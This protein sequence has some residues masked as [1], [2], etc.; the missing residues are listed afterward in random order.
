MF[1]VCVARRSDGEVNFRIVFPSDGRC[2]FW[3]DCSRIM[4]SFTPFT[5]IPMDRDCS[6]IGRSPAPYVQDV[7]SVPSSQGCLVATSL[8]ICVR[9]DQSSMSLAPAGS[10]L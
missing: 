1:G 8:D 7:T 10:L 2:A 4:P 9:I 6:L 3:Q 5:L